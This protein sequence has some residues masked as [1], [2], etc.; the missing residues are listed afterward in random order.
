MVDWKYNPENYNPNGFELIPVGDYR[1]RIDTAENK[2]S[3]S[4]KDM[5]R[6]TLSVSGYNTKVWFYLV[7]D[8]S[9]EEMRR[10]TDQRLGSI[11]DSFGISSGSM[12]VYDWEGKTGGAHIR[13]RPDQNGNM[14]SEVSYFL[15]RQKVDE[16]P[17]W[18][19]GP[20]ARD[21]EL[22]SAGDD[23]TSQAEFGGN[24]DTVPF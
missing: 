10:M 9:N 17:A 13:H 11:Y 5:I 23:F 12:E 20:K 6:L 21:P 14:R 4:G 24:I 19:E 22:E 7:F 1:V 15:T 16:L 8:S 3:R 18:G 2:V